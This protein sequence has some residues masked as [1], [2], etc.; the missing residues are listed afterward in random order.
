[1]QTT[2]PGLRRARHAEEPALASLADET[3]SLSITSILHPRD[4]VPRRPA[5]DGLLLRV[6][7]WKAAVRFQ[8]ADCGE[9]PFVQVAGGDL[10]L[11]VGQ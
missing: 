2:Y 3:S 4:G 7:G 10:V 1:M 5:M 11:R 6:P 8:G 9:L